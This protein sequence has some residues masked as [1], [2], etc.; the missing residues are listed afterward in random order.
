MTDREAPTGI[1]VT[2]PRGNAPFLREE[3]ARL[4]FRVVSVGEG[5]VE[6]EGSLPDTMRLNLLLRTAHRVLYRL[7]T[8]RARDA[9]ALYDRVTRIPW[10]DYLHAD[11]YFT[12]HAHV[13]NPTI[14]DTRFACLKAKDAIVDRIRRVRGVRPDTGP[15]RDR[16]SVFLHW[17]ENTCGV[18]LD[19]T[20]EALS[21]RGYRKIPL[22]APVRET[23]AAAAVLASG[24]DG[25]GA[26]VNPMC[27][28]GT[29]AIEAA[30][31]GLGRAPGLLRG[32][33]AFMH[34]RGFS[35]EAWEAL[36]KGAR[37]AARRDL[38]GRIVASDIRSAAVEAARKNARTA[39]VDHRIE[40]H[41]C[42][43]AET[44][45]PS[46]GGVVMLN[47]GYGARMGRVE[48]LEAVYEGI[49]DFFKRVCSGYT[50]GVLTGNPV[51]GKRVGLRTRRRIPLFNGPIECR[52][53]LYE[54]YAGSRK[55]RPA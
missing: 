44:P 40:F 6:T 50:G 15:S 23:T 1:R 13:D 55:P 24:W 49:G 51:L 19:T 17:K 52:L 43:Y 33:Y 53:L 32:N 14:R 27:G 42:P 20:G 38:E 3:M 30:M 22:D 4:G 12:V 37:A 25:A 34:L 35:R 28:S 18:Y 5:G 46:G 41:V 47:P 29:L 45:I 31:I 2:C 21:Q 11:G 8:V 16:A 10:E 36:R 54:L 9:D 26:F 7:R 48:E 39:G